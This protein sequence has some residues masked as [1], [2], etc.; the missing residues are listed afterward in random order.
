VLRRVGAMLEL[1]IR[2]RQRDHPHHPQPGLILLNELQCLPKP[3][4]PARGIEKI[5]TKGRLASLV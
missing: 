2:N 1:A 4:P 5:E 3:A